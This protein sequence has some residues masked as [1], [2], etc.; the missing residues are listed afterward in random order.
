MSEQ[1]Q[2]E[3]PFVVRGTND[4]AT[5]S[6]LQFSAS[7]DALLYDDN[8]SII[9]D[10]LKGSGDSP[11]SGMYASSVSLPP[12]VDTA[13]DTSLTMSPPG[14]R[15]PQHSERV[16]SGQHQ[17]AADSLAATLKPEPTRS[18]YVTDQFPKPQLFGKSISIISSI[19]KNGLD[20]NTNRPDWAEHLSTMKRNVSSFEVSEDESDLHRRRQ[21][22]NMREQQRS[23]QIT[24]QIDTLRQVLS[25]ANVA[26][27]P[28]KHSTLVSV[29]DYVTQL[30]QRSSSLD[31][32]HKKLLDTIAKTTEIING[33]YVPAS[34]SPPRPEV[35]LPEDE[36]VDFVRALDYKSVFV[37]C[38]FPFA[39]TNIDG[40]FMDCNVEFE[41]A[42]GYSRED[43]LPL[44]NQTGLTPLPTSSSDLTSKRNLSLFNVIRQDDMQQIFSAM[45]KM[46]QRV[47]Q[48]PVTGFDMDDFW[49]A[50]VSLNR[51]P[52][53]LVRT[54]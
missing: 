48:K 15:F 21:D 23:Q 37:A 6:E 49:T 42:I 3:S 27:K 52:N 38:P 22:R 12:V 9:N 54:F 1:A 31:K 35:G 32:E 39:I 43:V 14:Q 51:F 50:P 28:D 41:E 4:V 20:D 30:Q 7:L 8:A 2:G 5:M 24:G 47:F 46:L 29:V 10:A 53:K 13:D 45:S 33:L 17:P 40:R 26:F 18:A 16:P 11:S 25:E 36:S 34:L 44:E 19:P